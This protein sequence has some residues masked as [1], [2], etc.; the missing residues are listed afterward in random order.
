M[1]RSWPRASVVERGRRW[2]AL[3]SG[4]NVQVCSLSN[5]GQNPLSGQRVKDVQ[6][7][8]QA[9]QDLNLQQSWA[10]P[11]PSG[12][13]LPLLVIGWER[14]KASASFSPEDSDWFGHTLTSWKLFRLVLSRWICENSHLNLSNPAALHRQ[15]WADKKK[16]SFDCVWSHETAPLS[17]RGSVVV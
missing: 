7:Y 2:W 12:W 10:D 3:I 13:C 1:L 11:L 16:K 8:M 17:G 6:F 5:K 4:N 14:K 9:A 15:L